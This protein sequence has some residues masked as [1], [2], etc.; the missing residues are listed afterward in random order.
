MSAPT[1]VTH[2]PLTAYP[3]FDFGRGQLTAG[4][5]EC[6]DLHPHPHT[7]T[8]PPPLH[9]PE[10]QVEMMVENI[11]INNNVLHAANECGVDRC[12]SMTSTCVFPDKVQPRLLALHHD[13][14]RQLSPCS[15]TTSTPPRSLPAQSMTGTLPL[16]PLS[17]CVLSAL[18]SK[19]SDSV[20]PPGRVSNQ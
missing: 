4:P 9:A 5:A 11:Q 14:T 12:V 1:A 3:A 8:S 7:R 17:R 13:C 6:L 15:T 16:R 20:V 19:A 10:T 18:S 2:H